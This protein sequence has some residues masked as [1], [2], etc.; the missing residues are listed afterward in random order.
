M[1]DQQQADLHSHRRDISQHWSYSSERY[2]GGDNLLT[3]IERG[4][5]IDLRVVLRRQWFAGMRCIEIYHFTIRRAD[6]VAD[7]AVL[8]NPYVTRFLASQP[9]ELVEAEAAAV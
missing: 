8:G 4:W 3:A 9:Y 5:T 7:M 6:V 1:D 2:A